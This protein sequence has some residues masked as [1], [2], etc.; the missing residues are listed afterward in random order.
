M[1]NT[2]TSRQLPDVQVYFYDP[3]SPWQ[4]GAIS[5]EV[6]LSLPI[7]K[8]SSTKVSLLLNQR[9]KRL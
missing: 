8:S 6:P 1:A 7:L 2:G 5:H 9:P 3:Q 4:R